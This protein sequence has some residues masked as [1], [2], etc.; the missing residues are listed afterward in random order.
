MKL[1]L[2]DSLL[3]VPVALVY[4]GVR[5]EIDDVLVDTDSATTLL[6]IDAVA[7]LGI[8]PETTDS[9]RR[10]RGVGG[11]SMSFPD[12]SMRSLSANTKPHCWT[13]NSADWTMASR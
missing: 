3:F 7:S 2:R 8:Y 5:L 9:L 4:H 12:Q 10:I 6:S 1:I 11:W 13:S